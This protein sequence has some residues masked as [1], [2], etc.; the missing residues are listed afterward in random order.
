MVFMGL[1]CVFSVNKNI[2]TQISV[3]QSEITLILSLLHTEG[4]KNVDTF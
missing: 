3:E 2:I 1:I 4:A